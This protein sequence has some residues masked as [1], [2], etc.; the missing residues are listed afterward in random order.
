MKEFI[1]KN[2]KMI[3]IV[4]GIL[5][6]TGIVA[7][8]TG[9]YVF[10]S[11]DVRFDNTN[12]E[13][14]AGDVQGALEEVY[15]HVTDYNDI[16]DQIGNSTLTTTN[17]TL[18]GGINEVNS[19]IA[20]SADTIVSNIAGVKS[21]LSAFASQMQ[22][23]DAKLVRIVHTDSSDTSI[24]RPH[25]RYSGLLTKNNDDSFSWLASGTVDKEPVIFSFYSGNQYWV[26]EKLVTNSQI[27]SVNN[28]LT[29]LES[30]I[31]DD[32]GFHN[33]IFRGKNLG[34]SVTTSQW[35]A[36]S[37]GT[38]NDL[39][40]GDYWTINGVNWRIAGFDIYINKGDTCDNGTAC[41]KHHAVIVPDTNLT[42]AKMN[43]TNTTT[44]GYVGSKMYTDTL[45]TVLTTIRNAF[46][47]DHVLKYRN[48]LTTNVNGSL[49]NR[50]GLAGGVSNDWAWQDRYLDLMNE[51]QVYGSIAWSSSGYDTGSDNVQFPLFRL[52]PE[53][54]NKERGWYW[55]RNVASSAYFARVGGYGYSATDNASN[56]AGVRP[57]FYIG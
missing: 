51:N 50:L 23:G 1:K 13:I 33:S 27:A 10:E 5:S 57:Y 52:K 19:K 4:I 38:F 31:S 55:L 24:M 54:I 46:G 12:T 39:Y 7:Y 37:S 40:V 9:T 36:I 22:I 6:L 42:S 43:D 28:R 32:A 15:H 41:K 29:N 30:L 3:V 47:T 34:S 16:K 8:A 2:I 56:S 18:T 25:V 49:T 14:T 17:Q 44:G 21:A 26:A 45:P 53:F 35:T 11:T 20:K 48:L